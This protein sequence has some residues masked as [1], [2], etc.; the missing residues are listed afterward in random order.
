MT[1]GDENEADNQPQAG[2]GGS[3]LWSSG[4]VCIKFG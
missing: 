2:G 3:S 1:S 4:Q